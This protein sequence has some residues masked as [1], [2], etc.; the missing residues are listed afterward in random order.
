MSAVIN[1][2]KSLKAVDPVSHRRGVAVSQMS[3]P[4]T[5]N[6]LAHIEELTRDMY[7]EGILVVGPV[8]DDVNFG[9]FDCTSLSPGRMYYEPGIIIVGGSTKNDKRHPNS[10]V[11]G[12]GA[13]HCAHIYAP[14]HE[15]ISSVPGNNYAVIQANTAYAAA[16]VAGAAARLRTICPELTP[17]YVKDSLITGSLA[18]GVPCL[19]LDDSPLPANLLRVPHRSEPAECTQPARR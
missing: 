18:H 15:V 11:G 14:G 9:A 16:H 5:T 3:Y 17:F 6:W 12:R 10:I 1:D 13:V 8:G 19:D 7:R 2:Y 4:L